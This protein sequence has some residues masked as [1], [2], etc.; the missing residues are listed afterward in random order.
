[1]LYDHRTCLDLR[2]GSKVLRVPE[3]R[4]RSYRRPCPS[5][6]TTKRATSV[7]ALER[8]RERERRPGRALVM[9]A[10]DINTDTAQ[11]PADQ[12]STRKKHESRP[13]P[14]PQHARV[15]G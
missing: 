3:K 14:S 4:A 15:L 13:R 6:T 12:A 7:R 1:M 5:A 11:N 8:R 10:A 2:T 9:L